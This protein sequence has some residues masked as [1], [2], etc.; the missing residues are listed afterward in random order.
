MIREQLGLEQL[1]TK[2]VLGRILADFADESLNAI[3]K[4]LLLDK[5]FGIGIDMH[6]LADLFE[7]CYPSYQVVDIVQ[8]AIDDR[9]DD[10]FADSSIRLGTPSRSERFSPEVR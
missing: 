7:P 4:E 6:P 10:F 3:L 2:R 5:F 9:S 1:R 8:I